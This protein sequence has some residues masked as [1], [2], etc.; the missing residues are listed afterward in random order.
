MKFLIASVVLASMS[1][2]AP[3]NLV[4]EDSSG[5]ALKDEL[6]IVQD[7]RSRE[8]EVLRV[9]SGGTGKIPT[10]DLPPGLYR[11]IA[12]A[13]YGLWQTEVQEFLVGKS[14]CVLLYICDQCQHAEMEKSSPWEQ[15]GKN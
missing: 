14:R 4:V 11:A 8:H 9:L 5:V 15:R 7:L 2:S 6:V 12:T 1:Y 3:V 13:P 10:M